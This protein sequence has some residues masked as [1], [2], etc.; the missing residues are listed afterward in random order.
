[1]RS[2][3]VLERTQPHIIDAGPLAKESGPGL[4]DGKISTDA[5]TEKLGKAAVEGAIGR[6]GD[7]FAAVRPDAPTQCIDGR[8]CTGH[9]HPL[10]AKIP[11]GTAGVAFADA[12][13]RGDAA[14]GGHTFADDL[15][16]L[17]IRY[18]EQG[19]PVGDHVDDHD[20]SDGRGIGCGAIDKMP[21]ALL[22]MADPAFGKYIGPY[23]KTIL[24][25]DYDPRTA[26]S[27]L[28]RA[29]K[30]AGRSDE[31]FCKGYAMR[32]KEA[33]ES[34]GPGSVETLT[35]DHSEIA[36]VVNMVPGT[37]FDRDAFA[38]AHD[39]TMEAFDYDFWQ[40]RVDAERLY[41][42]DREKQREFLTASVMVAIAT[43]MK[44][45]DGSTRLLIRR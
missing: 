45:S 13:V 42:G 6:I 36:L 22:K 29:K 28:A 17:V 18:R 40:V 38:E 27:I 2:T 30:L 35:G 43:M 44:L 5:I 16:R 12:L 15:S 37:T 20:H 8:H 7:S 21:E 10:G 19:F 33:L 1:M 11:G 25:A 14:G 31:Y 39:G 4:W 24:G 26:R 3:A 32:A 34:A 9:R 41:P 23:L